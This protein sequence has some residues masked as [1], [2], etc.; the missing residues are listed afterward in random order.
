MLRKPRKSRQRITIKRT[1]LEILTLYFFIRINGTKKKF[2]M[3]KTFAEAISG[4][5]L[6]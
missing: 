2:M 5:K 3:K 6:R 4:D 1:L